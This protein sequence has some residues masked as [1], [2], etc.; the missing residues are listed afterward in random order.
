MKFTLMKFILMKFIL[1]KFRN[2]NISVTLF[3]HYFSRIEVNSDYYINFF[4]PVSY[5]CFIHR[6]L[7]PSLLLSSALRFSPR[8]TVDKMLK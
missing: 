3:F 6:D 2:Y 1:M 7:S 5:S 4:I 8:P